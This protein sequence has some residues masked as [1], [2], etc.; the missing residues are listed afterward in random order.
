MTTIEV[1]AGQT[2]P[3]YLYLRTDDAVPTNPDGT[4]L[5]MSGMS[6]VFVVHDLAGNVL[7]ISGSVSVQ[8]SAL[9]LVKYLP[10]AGDLMVGIYR[11]RVK[12]TDGAGKIGYFPQAA[13]D[14]LIVR[15]A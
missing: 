9:W 15:A 6:C 5:T 13:W 12:V 10:A 4:A 3:I 8:D 2:A 14:E 11:S 1:V 7:T